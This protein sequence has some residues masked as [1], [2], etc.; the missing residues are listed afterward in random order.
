[1]YKFCV[2]NNIGVTRKIVTIH[3]LKADKLRAGIRGGKRIVMTP[4]SSTAE[5]KGTRRS[6]AGYDHVTF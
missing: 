4:S 1:M 6:G 5:D 2:K 3:A